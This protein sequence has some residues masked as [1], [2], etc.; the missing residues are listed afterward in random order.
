V[1][2]GFRAEEPKRLIPLLR[3]AL[4]TA[5][6]GTP[7]PVYLEVP[8]HLLRKEIPRPSHT[9]PL[10]DGSSVEPSITDSEAL[11]T[12][13]RSRRPMLL[14]G[15]G[16]RHVNTDGGIE[17][18]A[19]TLG[20]GILSTA[21]GRGTVPEEHHLFLGLSGL[22]ANSTATSLLEECDCLISLGSRPEENARFGWTGGTRGGTPGVQAE[23]DAAGQSA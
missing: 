7:G 10:L 22:Y 20:A 19:E 14:V 6:A 2:A 4:L 5:S 16:S 12:L 3:R 17:R 13:M 15:G 9:G 11:R 21:S 23:L 18:L 1:K 8:D